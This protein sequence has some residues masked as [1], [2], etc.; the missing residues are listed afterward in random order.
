MI[1]DIITDG[2]QKGVHLP[3]D[4]IMKATQQR[5]DLLNEV[6][7]PQ[8]VDFDLWAGNVFL[9]S[10]DG[11]WYISGIIDFE[12]AFLGDPYA[13]FIA[14]VNIYS[15][16]NDERTFVE[17]YSSAT[18]GFQISKKDNERMQLYRLYKWGVFPLP[19]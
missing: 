19:T 10:K 3:Y 13:D 1:Q 8:L 6:Q 16:I 4:R 9:D 2:K 7:V 18:E 17:G 14:S 5:K 11:Q 15:D 12:R